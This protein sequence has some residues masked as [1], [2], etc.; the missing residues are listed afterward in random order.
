MS[1][2]ANILSTKPVIKA[3]ASMHND[4]GGGNLGYMSQGRK[5]KDETKRYLDENI[6]I[7]P[8][9]K[10]IFSFDSEPDMPEDNFSV[11]DLINQIVDFIQK[12]FIKK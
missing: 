6:S 2:D 9:G 7:K 11:S 1:F 3:A 4:G 12:L 8:Q 10:D 5:K